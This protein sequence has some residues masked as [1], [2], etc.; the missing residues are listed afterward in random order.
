MKI[1]KLQNLFYCWLKKKL[2][3]RKKNNKL[4]LFKLVLGKIATTKSSATAKS[5]E[6]QLHSGGS[7]LQQ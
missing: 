3:E 4:Y 2:I 5:H 7:S 1:Y 6:I